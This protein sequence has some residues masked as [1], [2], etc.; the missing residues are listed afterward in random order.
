MNEI[1][2]N[3]IRTTFIKQSGRMRALNHLARL[4]PEA[5]A[6][7]LKDGEEEAAQR[8]DRLGEIMGAFFPTAQNRQ[9]EK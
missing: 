6:E 9:N 3:K 5:F 4:Y 2:E 1:R 7:L 8:Y